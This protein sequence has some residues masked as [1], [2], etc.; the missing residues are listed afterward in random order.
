MVG[1]YPAY[2]PESILM[3]YNFEDINL[4]IYKIYDYRF[5]GELRDGLTIEQ[6]EKHVINSLDVSM[7]V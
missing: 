6:M 4:D 3:E 1:I 2:K 7:E 5:F